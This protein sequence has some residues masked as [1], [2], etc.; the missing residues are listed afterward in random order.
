M[1]RVLL[2]ASYESKHLI[3]GMRFSASAG[4]VSDPRYNFFGF[5]GDACEYNP[6]KSGNYLM[7]R[8][9]FRF[10]SDF[11]GKMGG[12]LNWVAGV[13]FWNFK[14]GEVQQKYGG[15]NV[16]TVYSRYVR[17]GVIKSSEAS[18]GS[19]LEFKAGLCY[20]SRDKEAAPDRGI[21]AELY[22]N[23][24]PDFFGDGH[25]YLKFNAHFRHYLSIPLNIPAGN[26]VFA[27]HLAYQSTVAGDAPFY[28]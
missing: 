27:Y 3:P 25:S 1:G 14:T 18:G 19:R 28:M 17:Y 4:Y 22:C 9:F 6:L 5:N 8:N 2:F 23:G 24:S 7:S 11:Q 15:E 13:S 10:I 12:H 20:D 26:P 21:W 16:E